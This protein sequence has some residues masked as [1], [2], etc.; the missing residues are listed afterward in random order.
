AR[1]RELLRVGS[2][3]LAKWTRPPTG[4]VLAPLRG[5]DAS[6]VL[7][8]EGGTCDGDCAPAG[9]QPE[10]IGVDDDAILSASA[11]IDRGTGRWELNVYLT[12]RGTSALRAASL[13][14]ASRTVG[15]PENQMAVFVDRLMVSNGNVPGVL[16]SGSFSISGAR[17]ASDAAFRA[18]LLAWLKSGGMSITILSLKPLA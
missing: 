3:H 15:T 2:V 12:A 6:S 11:A 16:D 8:S 7:R 1:T 17:I 10:A 4:S 18:D 9:Y 5:I 14:L 13:D